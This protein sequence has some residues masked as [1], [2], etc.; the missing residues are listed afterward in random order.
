MKSDLL[1]PPAKIEEYYQKHKDQFSSKAQVKLRMIMIP[2]RADEGVGVQV[3][4]VV[5]QELLWPVPLAVDREVE[6]VV[7]VTGV[8]Q[9]APQPRRAQKMSC[10]VL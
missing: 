5:G 7:R 4:L 8:A 10:R 9:V 3:A 1:I 6:H 2:G